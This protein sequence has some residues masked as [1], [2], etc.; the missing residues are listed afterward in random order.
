MFSIPLSQGL[1]IGLEKMKGVQ[2]KQNVTCNDILLN[3]AVNK[4][5]VGLRAL[6]RMFNTNP[7]KIFIDI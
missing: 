2:S 3:V 1:K 4:E 6:S 5:V 7:M